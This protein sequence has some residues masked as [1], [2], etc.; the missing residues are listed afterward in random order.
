MPMS[1]RGSVTAAP[2]ISSTPF[3][4]PTSPAT[5]RS[6]VDLPQPDGP[7]SETELVARHL[8]GHVVERNDAPAV[9]GVKDFREPLNPD[10]GGAPCRP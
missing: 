6:M 8:H 10:H 2:S 5:R 4:A 1:R 9:P 7:T 3:V